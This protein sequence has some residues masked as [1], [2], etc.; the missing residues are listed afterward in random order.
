MPGRAPDSAGVVVLGAA[1][2]GA[3]L[4]LADSVLAGVVVLGGVVVFAAPD[5]SFFAGVVVFAAPDSG[6]FAA[7]VVDFFGADSSPFLSVV[8][9]L[10]PC[11]MLDSL[12]MHPA[13]AQH[14]RLVHCSSRTNRHHY[15]CHK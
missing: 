1:P 12:H 9:G 6:F 7:S 10:P 5:S 14:Q 2:A 13:V 11:W 3:V 4:P 15:W 8:A